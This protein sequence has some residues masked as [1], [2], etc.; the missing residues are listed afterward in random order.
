VE[1]I[2]TE[3]GMTLNIGIPE[4]TDDPHGERLLIAARASTT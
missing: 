4:D 3:L 2:P 1:Q